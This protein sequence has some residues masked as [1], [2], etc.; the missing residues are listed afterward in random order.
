MPGRIT[1]STLELT[2]LRVPFLFFPVKGQMEQEITIANRL[3]RHKAGLRMS[4]A[5]TTPESLAAPS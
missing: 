1:P 2:A 5:K 3:A 4:L